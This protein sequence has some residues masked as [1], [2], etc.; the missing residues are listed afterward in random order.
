MSIDLNFLMIVNC[1][2]IGIFFN[3]LRMIDNSDSNACAWFDFLTDFCEV[4]MRNNSEQ[5]TSTMIDEE[6]DT[7]IVAVHRC[8]MIETNLNALNRMTYHCDCVNDC[9]QWIVFNHLTHIF[10]KL[11]R[12][13]AR[14][15]R[16]QNVVEQSCENHQK[17]NQQKK[18][19][20]RAKRRNVW[21]IKTNENELCCWLL[22]SQSEFYF[23]E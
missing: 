5:K 22:S 2:N 19:W 17:F 10:D 11:Q 14:N 3:Q 20:D 1:L 23:V 13:I 4:K 18:W 21:K 12:R 9:F 15:R 8:T 6:N 7:S 16:I